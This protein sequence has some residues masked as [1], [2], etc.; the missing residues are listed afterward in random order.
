MAGFAGLPH[1]CLSRGH[2]AG[3]EYAKGIP[4]DLLRGLGLRA[5]LYITKSLHFVGL[6]RPPRNEVCCLRF[7][8]L[9]DLTR[10]VAKG[11]VLFILYSIV[12]GLF[13]CFYY[14]CNSRA[15]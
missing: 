9:L 13:C 7:L 12:K 2:G 14:F 1:G 4:L 15:C 5:L 11:I 8:S 6:C 3:L 10:L